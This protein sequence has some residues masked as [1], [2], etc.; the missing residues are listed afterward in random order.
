MS[1]KKPYRRRRS[2][3]DRRT[4]IVEANKMFFQ[5]LRNKKENT[6]EARPVLPETMFE[7]FRNRRN[8]PAITAY[9]QRNRSITVK[10]LKIDK[11]ILDNPQ[12]LNDFVASF[13]GDTKDDDTNSLSMLFAGDANMYPIPLIINHEY[14]MV[15]LS[16][17]DPLKNALSFRTYYTPIRG[18]WEALTSLP[19][20]A[21]KGVF[22]IK[23]TGQK[24]EVIRWPYDP[25]ITRPFHPSKGYTM[26][27]G[28][29]L[30]LHR[31]YELFEKSL[32]DRLN[33]E[34][35]LKPVES[36]IIQ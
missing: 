17:K 4:V 32:T 20:W 13:F 7:I 36:I 28:R 22:T 19:E 12:E 18:W 3:W 9:L 5:I 14:A 34:L 6:W 1:Q 15:D 21:I 2:G 26:Y 31:Y 30:N 25:S 29:D 24:T 35:E 33:K 27:I 23:A 10:N 8:I 16:K 11:K